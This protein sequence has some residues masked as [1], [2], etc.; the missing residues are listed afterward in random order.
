MEV[1]GKLTALHRNT[2]C[3]FRVGNKLSITD[4][5]DRLFITDVSNRMSLLDVGGRL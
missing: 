2:G 4:L 1:D 5:G 3:P